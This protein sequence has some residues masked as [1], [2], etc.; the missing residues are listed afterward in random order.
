MRELIERTSLPYPAIGAQVGVCAATVRRWHA[1]E[2]WVRPAPGE[3]V[4]P[5][6]N[7]P[8]VS[9]LPNP[10]FKRGR[11]RRY[12]PDVVERVRVLVEGTGLSEAA[13]AARTGL[14]VTTIHRWRAERGWARPL[15]AS[16]WTRTVAVDRAGLGEDLPAGFARVEAL[17]RRALGRLAGEEH[18]AAR[19]EAGRLAAAA[20]R[21]GRRYARTRP[22][23][24]VWSLPA[25][26]DWP[27]VRVGPRLPAGRDR[28]RGDELV[29]SARDLMEGT[30]IRQSDIARQLGLSVPTLIAWARDGGWIRPLDAPSPFGGPKRNRRWE[31]RM[32]DRIEAR[33]RLREAERLLDA[34]E[35]EESAALARIADAFAALRRVA[36]ALRRWPALPGAAPGQ[37]GAGS[38]VSKHQIV[39]VS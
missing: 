26:D 10:R 5:D 15:A 21:T 3:G 39:D 22:G 13:I 14:G 6:P 37:G 35:R 34:L 32:D 19:A 29:A 23:A 9:P 27:R 11:G 17:A 36:D 4:P 38:L 30:T 33:R 20:R 16:P 8:I 24:P 2:G 31:E 28:P 18:E 25:L 12:V 7:V 1:R